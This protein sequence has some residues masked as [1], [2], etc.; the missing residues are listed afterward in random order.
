MKNPSLDSIV[1]PGPYAAHDIVCTGLRFPEGPVALPD[2]SVL[3]VEIERGCLTRIQ[4]DGAAS[5]AAQTGG[6]PNGAAVGPD[7]AIYVCNN[8]GFEWA[9]GDGLLRPA[10]QPADYR[11]GSIQRVDLRTGQVDTLYD[12][13]DGHVLAGPNDLVF[14]RHGGFYFT[15]NGKRRPREADR[16]GVY[17]AL[18]DGSS[19]REVIFPI[20]FPNGVGLS[21]AEDLL[22]VAETETGRLWAFDIVAPG[23]LRLLPYPSPNG[24]RYAFGSSH[25]QRFDSLKVEQD[26]RV[27]VATL[28]RGGITT[29]DPDGGNETFDALD[30]RMVTNLC[31]GGDDMRT[32]WITLSSTGRL[33]RMRW[34]RPGLKLNFQDL[35]RC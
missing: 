18:P 9:R 2:G 11:G 16:G 20:F 29:V 5:V 8:G 12:A 23:Q 25:Y 15:C 22:Y 10:G 33:A 31:F 27:C 32:A 26:G 1:P 19:I 21:P 30:D 7:G 13:C 24:G 17:Y 34:P 4:P 3:V 35:A 14:D 6:G 28:S